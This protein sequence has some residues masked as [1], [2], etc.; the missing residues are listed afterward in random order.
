ML[1]QNLKLN[2]KVFNEDVEKKS[3][4]LGFGE[5]LLEAGIEN[6]NVVALCGDLKDPTKM[7]LFADKFHNRY[8]EMGIAEQ[9]MASVASGMA[10][11]G[12][13][14]FVGS[15][16]VCNPG[17]NWEQIRTTICY[18]NQPVKII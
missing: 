9:N 6:D 15:F 11:M 7:N 17:R 14:P 5:G 10:A 8:I 4:R 16:A 13:V 18:N 12:K 1:N 2:T 3:T